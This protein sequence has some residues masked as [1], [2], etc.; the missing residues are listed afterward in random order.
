[1]G[2]EEKAEELGVTILDGYPPNGWWACYDPD[3]HTILRHAELG[4]LQ[5]RS[6]TWHELG[7]AHYRH[8]GCNP[9]YAHLWPND[10]DRMVAASDGL[11]VLP[12]KKLPENSLDSEAA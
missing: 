1:M 9:T 3:S 4:A 8:I 10:D 12:E 7:H 5:R 6:C 11:V 2:Y